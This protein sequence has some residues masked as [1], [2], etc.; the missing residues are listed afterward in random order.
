MHFITSPFK[1]AEKVPIETDFGED[2]LKP[3]KN[4]NFINEVHGLHYDVT[5]QVGYWGKIQMLAFV[6]I[7]LEQEEILLLYIAW[8]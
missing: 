7:V 8:L 2:I 6:Y 5:S 1:W 4:H 3:L